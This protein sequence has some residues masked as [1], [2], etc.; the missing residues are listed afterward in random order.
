M[1]VAFAGIWFFSFIDRSDQAKDEAKNFLRQ[2]VRS[3]TGI[4]AAGSE[5]KVD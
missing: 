1:S 3:E 2:F 4:G 5:F